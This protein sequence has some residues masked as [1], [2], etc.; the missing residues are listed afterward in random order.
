[1]KTNTQIEDACAILRARFGEEAKNILHIKVS[2]EQSVAKFATDLNNPTLTPDELVAEYLA[3][4]A[5]YQ[6]L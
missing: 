3:E 6:A 1:M 2:L 4:N 5:D